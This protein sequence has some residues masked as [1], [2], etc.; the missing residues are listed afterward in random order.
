MQARRAVFAIAAMACWWG[1]GCAGEVVP[2]LYVAQAITTGQMEEHR[3]AAF[4]QC[5]LDVLVKVSG[6]P[7]LTDDPRAIALSQH[8]A[9]FVQAY[10]YRDRLEGKPIHDEQGTR[11]RPHDLTVD[12]VPERIGYALQLLGR[13]PW[14]PV[15][16]TLALVTSVR[17]GEISYLLTQEEERGVNQREALAAASIRIG[18]PVVLP[19]R[20][21]LSQAG[22]AVASL[23]SISP[24]AANDI[25][26]RVGA[27]VPL[28]GT[29]VFSAEAQGWVVDWRLIRPEGEVHWQV[30]GVN[31]DEAFRRALR[32]AAQVL[33]GNGTPN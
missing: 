2:N 18:V 21:T 5:F 13:K 22:V 19:P 4:A 30:R 16:P 14:D 26:A 24:G 28:L 25:T 10:R 27:D 31:Y 6:D 7:R 32:G 3:P 15:R 20:S 11:D 29:M 8:A 33:S 23:P 9:T 12:F 1:P 17:F